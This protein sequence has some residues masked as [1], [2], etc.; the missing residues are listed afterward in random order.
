ML[1]CATILNQQP[2]LR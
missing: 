2:S 1:R